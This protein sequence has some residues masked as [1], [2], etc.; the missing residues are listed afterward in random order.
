MTKKTLNTILITSFAAISLSAC[1]MMGERLNN[2]GKDPAMASIENPVTRPGY[3][4]VSMPMPERRVEI[5]QANSLWMSGRKSFFKDQRAGSVGDILTVLVDIQDNAKLENKSQKI[6]SA[7]ESLGV[8]GLFGFESHL[9]KVLPNAVDPEALIG[10]ES[11]TRDIG[12]GKIERKEDVQLKVAAVVTQILPNGNLVI[13]G[14]QQVRISNER[15]DLE[16]AGIIRPE[17]I[18]TQNSIGYE[19]IA[20]ARIAYGGQGMLT[21]TNRPRYGNEVMDIILPF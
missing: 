21:D 1:G 13:H 20:E 6:K 7:D 18:T 19:K 15:R 10:T 12:N 8:P 14:R 17:D 4:P 9:N 5:Q 16:V 3:V 11:S 2:V